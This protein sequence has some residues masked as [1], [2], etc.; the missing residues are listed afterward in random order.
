MS[1][2]KKKKEHDVGCVYVINAI[3]IFEICSLCTHFDEDCYIMNRC[4]TLSHVLISA[5]TF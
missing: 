5:T 2:K 3:I 1:S 4:W